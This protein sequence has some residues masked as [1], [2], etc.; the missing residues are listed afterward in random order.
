MATNDT[1]VLLDAL[2]EYHASLQRHMIELRTEFDRLENRWHAFSYFYEGDAANQFRSH[3]GG[4]VDRF[5]E[6]QDRTDAL[7]RV[8]EARIEALRR[9][10][11]TESGV[12]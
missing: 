5:R 9:V 3:W 11:Q 8:L 4:T 7:N 6:Y 2:E 10:N 12:L 1:R